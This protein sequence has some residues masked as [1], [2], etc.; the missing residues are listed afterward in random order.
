MSTAIAPQSSSVPAK[1]DKPKRMQIRGKLKA[2]LDLMVYGDA[3]G[4]RYDHV[5][6]PRKV[7]FTPQAMRKAIERP[8][9]QRYLAEQKQVFR[10]SLS[11]ANIH[12]LGEIR[13]DAGNA[14]A[15]L[16]AVKLL[17]QL[18]E[19]AP[20]ASSG[21]RAVM[22]GVVVIVNQG[23]QRGGVIGHDTLIE[24]NPLSVQEDVPDEA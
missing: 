4:N 16:G 13:D 24:V 9:V 19:R 11:A 18:D 21:Q 17:E 7:G 5:S 15:R 10:K 1:P 8:H 2:A 3:E 12:V 23:A 22:P 14:M 6:A 20:A